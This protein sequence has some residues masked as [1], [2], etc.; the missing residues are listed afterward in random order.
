M[1]KIIQNGIGS[2]KVTKLY[3]LEKTYNSEFSQLNQPLGKIQAT[4]YVFQNIPRFALEL[5]GFIAIITALNY[6][7]RRINQGNANSLKIAKTNQKQ[8]KTR[9]KQA[10]MHSS[11]GLDDPCSYFPLRFS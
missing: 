2:I 5:I 7:F 8:A 3:D 11:A 9:Q 6:G 1:V 4:T 10:K